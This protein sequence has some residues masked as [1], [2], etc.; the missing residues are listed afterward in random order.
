ML[1]KLLIFEHSIYEELQ[2][3]NRNVKNKIII[4]GIVVQYKTIL[5]H[6]MLKFIMS[7]A[8]TVFSSL[9]LLQI[10][11][12]MLPDSWKLFFSIRR[13]CLVVQ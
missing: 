9:C 8:K 7:F 10:K 13:T 5:K 1:I 3:E 6:F 2:S 4:T 11:G 12:R